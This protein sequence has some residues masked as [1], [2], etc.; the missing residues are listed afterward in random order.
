MTFEEALY[1]HV[2]GKM[3]SLCDCPG[4]LSRILTGVISCHDKLLLGAL[5]HRIYPQAVGH[6]NYQVTIKAQTIVSFS[7]VDNSTLD[8]LSQESSIL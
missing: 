1:I 6:I 7:V 8:C 2:V 5:C 4:S 3:K